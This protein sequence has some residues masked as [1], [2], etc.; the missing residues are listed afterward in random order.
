MS[1][2]TIE[3]QKQ[4]YSR[5]LALHT[6]RQWNAVRE[7]QSQDSTGTPNHEVGRPDRGTTRAESTDDR[8]RANKPE[9]GD[10]KGQLGI[11]HAL[12]DFNRRKRIV[13]LRG[14]RRIWH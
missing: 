10:K 1:A 11:L 6:F 2:R 13:G 3:Q 5:Q 14:W 4:H 8:T 7:I 12:L 9:M